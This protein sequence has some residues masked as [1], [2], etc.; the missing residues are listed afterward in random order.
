MNPYIW[1]GVYEPTTTSPEVTSPPPFQVR[2][3]SLHGSGLPG[4]LPK[5]PPIMSSVAPS[6]FAHPIMGCPTSA[7]TLLAVTV[8]PQLTSLP[9][10]R[11]QVAVVTRTLLSLFVCVAKP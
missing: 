10:I 11:T 6:S 1:V 8:P 9:S 7:P 5:K 3:A 2:A 4:K